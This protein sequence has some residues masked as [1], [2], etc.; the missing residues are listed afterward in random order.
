MFYHEQLSNLMDKYP[1]WAE[2]AEEVADLTLFETDPLDQDDAVESG[3]ELGIRATINQSTIFTANSNYCVC[4]FVA[5]GENEVLARV[6][7]ALQ[8]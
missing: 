8:R 5:K 6:Q 1:K 3:V 2:A 7:T 4:Y